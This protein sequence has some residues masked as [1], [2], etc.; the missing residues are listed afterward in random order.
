MCE[1]KL[2]LGCGQADLRF[3]LKLIMIRSV[4]PRGKAAY[5]MLF[6]DSYSKSV[7]V[8][9]ILVHYKKYSIW[10]WNQG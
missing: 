4:M 1:T 9:L 5:N 10:V 7:T 3:Q 6:L 2:I 8:S